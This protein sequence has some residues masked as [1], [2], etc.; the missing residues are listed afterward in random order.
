MTKYTYP[1]VLIHHHHATTAIKPQHY[2][3]ISMTT[4]SF[5]HLITVTMLPPSHGRYHHIATI[6]RRPPPS[7]YRNPHTTTTITPPPPSP[8]G[9]GLVF[10]VYPEGLSTLDGANVWSV[11]FFFMMFLLGLGSSLT[12]VENVL[13]TLIDEYPVFRKTQLR[14]ALTRIG[15]CFIFFLLGRN[16]AQYNFPLIS[17]IVS[18]PGVLGDLGDLGDLGGLGA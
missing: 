2:H 16:Y 6:L 17:S 8:S 11:F 3:A 15:I 9:P 10:I 18:H 4:I 7:H 14:N 5:N 13:S 1:S 12:M